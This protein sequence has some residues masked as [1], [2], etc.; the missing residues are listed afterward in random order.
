MG[1]DPVP[2]ENSS[3]RDLKDGVCMLF[4]QRCALHIHFPC[5]QWALI[6]PHWFVCFV[7]DL[8]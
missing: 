5:F 3:K 4:F 2:T 7:S 6:V 8:V 1:G